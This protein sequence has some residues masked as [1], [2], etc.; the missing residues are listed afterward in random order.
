MYWGPKGRN[1]IWM[2]PDPFLAHAAGEQVQTAKADEPV[3][4]KQQDPTDQVEGILC[5]RM[6]QWLGHIYFKGY[7][8]L[9][10]K[11]RIFVLLVWLNLYFFRNHIGPISESQSFH[12]HFNFALTISE[13]S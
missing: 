3:M 4:W 1:Q 9:E 13:I 10:S 8:Q 6:D 7:W 5:L 12:L 2:Y 11:T